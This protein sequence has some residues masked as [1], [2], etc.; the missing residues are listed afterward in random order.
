MGLPAPK[1]GV[2]GWSRIVLALSHE[3]LYSAF[4]DT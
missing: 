3:S 2:R 1:L 4:D